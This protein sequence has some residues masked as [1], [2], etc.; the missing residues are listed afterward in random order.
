MGIKHSTVKHPPLFTVE[1]SRALRGQIP[2]GHTKNLFLKDKKGEL[3]HVTAWQESTIDLKA[4]PARINMG[5][6][7][8]GSAALMQE[9]LGVTPGTVTALALMNDVHKRIKTFVVD[10]ALMGFDVVNCHPLRND[11][12]TALKP[13]DLLAFARDAGFEPV[14]L[15]FGT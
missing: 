12:T 13:A 4:L 5:R 15:A 1:Q 2:G 10:S 7:S 9:V 3:C 8:F 6:F 14:L 11:R